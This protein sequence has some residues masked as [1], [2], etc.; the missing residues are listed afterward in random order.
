MQE[1]LIDLKSRR[2]CRKYTQQ[3]VCEE[4]LNAVLEAAT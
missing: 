4:Q 1:T 2:S 3:Q